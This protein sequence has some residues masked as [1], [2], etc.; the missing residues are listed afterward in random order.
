MRICSILFVVLLDHYVSAKYLA[1]ARIRFFFPVACCLLD[2]HIVINESASIWISKG[3]SSMY[4]VIG[5]SL[6]SK[7]IAV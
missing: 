2:S 4:D 1:A 6:G 5:C 3:S 7:P